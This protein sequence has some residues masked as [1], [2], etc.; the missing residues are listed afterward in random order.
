MKTFSLRTQFLFVIGFF[1]VVLTATLSISYA[2]RLRSLLRLENS[3]KQD[4]GLLGELPRLRAYLRSIDM[5]TDDYLL[6][7]DAKW[8]QV[9]EDAI[10]RAQRAFDS[11]HPLLKDQREIVVW[12]RVEKA[13]ESFLKGQEDLALRWRSGRVPL[14]EAARQLILNDDES[15]TLVQ[16]IQTLHDVNVEEVNAHL[17]RAKSA[18]MKTFLWLLG[19]TV[20]MVLLAGYAVSRTVLRPIAAMERYLREWKLGDPL[21]FRSASRGDKEGPARTVSLNRRSLFH[22][23]E[24]DALFTD[25]ENMTLRLNKQYAGEKEL[26]ELKSQ[27]VSLVSHEFNGAL[28]IIRLAASVL[29]TGESKGESEE[30]HNLYRLIASNVTSLSAAATNVLNLGRF[31]EG[32]FILRPSRIEPRW[33]FDSLVL[34]LAPFIEKKKLSVTLNAPGDVPVVAADYDVV[35]S[36]LLS[37]AVKYTPEGGRIVLSI[38]RWSEDRAEFS[39]ADTGIG[40]A[41]E[42]REKIFSGFY[43]TNEGMRSAK[44]I[45]LG[46]SLVKKLLEFHGAELALESEVGKGSRFSFRLPLWQGD[47]PIPPAPR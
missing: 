14:P 20:L 28:G 31:D 42:D 26:G 2:V 29:E 45:G 35:L 44:G 25:L 43:R 13:L 16:E 24:M 7:G 10:R 15:D 23:R 19:A 11:V 33:M 34:S 3:F 39:V 47:P 40:V 37:I 30:R 9:R 21:N 6:T 4:L 12:D 32:K 8:L 5:L 36:N 46:L 41:P 22:S 18:S 17:S 38:H 27:L 1:S